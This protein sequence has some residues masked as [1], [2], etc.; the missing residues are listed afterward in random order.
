MSVVVRNISNFRVYHKPKL[1]IPT[2]TAKILLPVSNQSE[3]VIS[4]PIRHKLDWTASKGR[5]AQRDFCIV[6]VYF[7]LLFGAMT[8]IFVILE[9]R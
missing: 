3:L 4:G 8:K 5:R 2:V 1:E 7:I 9:N 6:T